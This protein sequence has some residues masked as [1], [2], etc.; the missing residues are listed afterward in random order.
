M[1]KPQIIYVNNGIANN[2]GDTIEMN[3]W[4]VNYPK[5]YQAILKHELSHAPGKWD[6]SDLKLK[7]R[8]SVV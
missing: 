5:L 4:L 1:N 6:L 3:R 2:F 7:D 8:K